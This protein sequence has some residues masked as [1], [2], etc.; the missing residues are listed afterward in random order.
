M[1]VSHACSPGYCVGCNRF[2]TARA[3]NFIV[4]LLRNSPCKP[5]TLNSKPEA[6]SLLSL[7]IKK[8]T[9][10][11]SSRMEKQSMHSLYGWICLLFSLNPKPCICLFQI[12]GLF[13]GFAIGRILQREVY[14]RNPPPPSPMENVHVRC[15]LSSSSAFQV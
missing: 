15:V 10:L 5:Q 7:A 2:V 4:V 8:C 14:K 11:S 3:R 13:L 6:I 12:L 9:C 1:R